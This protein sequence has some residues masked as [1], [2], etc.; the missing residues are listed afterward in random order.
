MAIF[1]PLRRKA[2]GEIRNYNANSHQPLEYDDEEYYD[3]FREET[4]NSRWELETND[5]LERYEHSLRCEKQDPKTQRWY[6]PGYA[7]SKLNDTGVADTIADLRSIMHKGTYLGNIDHN[8]AVDETKAEARAYMKK[9]IFNYENW[10]VD[11]SQIQS[12]V[13]MFAREVHLALTRPVGDRE[14]GHRDKRMKIKQEIKDDLDQAN[15]Q[16]KL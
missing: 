2:R 6:K 11:K 12:L 5:V 4:D 7:K 15:N 3:D 1:D 13:L 10:E 8:Y 9:L 14:R 16:I